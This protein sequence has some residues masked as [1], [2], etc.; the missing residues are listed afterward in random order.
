MENSSL[1]KS[2]RCPTCGRPFRRTG[3]IIISAL[4]GSVI[5]L[6][7]GVGF[8][9]YWFGTYAGFFH[10]MAIVHEVAGALL[11]LLGGLI[12]GFWRQR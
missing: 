10:F 8:V 2:G 12:V 9:A 3:R 11:G 7:V 5:G 6:G 1:E 4:V